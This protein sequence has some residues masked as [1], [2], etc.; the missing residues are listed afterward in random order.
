MFKPYEFNLIDALLGL[1]R[2]E[3]EAREAID[4][5][6]PL[7]F[8]NSVAI[9]AILQL[10]SQLVE[11][12]M[13]GV[14]EGSVA[15]MFAQTAVNALI[16]DGHV[17]S[18]DSGCCACGHG[19]GNAMT[20]KAAIAQ[21]TQDIQ[22]LIDTG[23]ISLTFDGLIDAVTDLTGLS[24]DAVSSAYMDVADTYSKM[25]LPLANE[26]AGTDLPADTSTTGS[27]TVGG[28]ASG[29]RST[30]TDEDWFAI[31]LEAGVEY[32]F[33]M[34][35]SGDNPHED[36]LLNLYD[37]NGALIQTNDD[38]DI[39]GD[40]A[41]E[42]RNSLMFFTATESGTFYLGASGWT[43]T[44]GDYTVF[45][46]RSDERPDFSI[47]EQAFF[48]TD[49]FDNPESWNQ[50]TITYDVSGLADGAKTLA[51]AAMELWAEAS[52]IVF[53]ESTGGTADLTFNEDNGEDDGQ[54]AFASTT[55]SNGVITSARITVS[56][57]WDLNGDGSANYAF[58]S[59]RYQTY[60]HEVGHALGLG[61]AGPYNGI[62]SSGGRDFNV[63]NQDAWNY[64]VMSYFD[65]GEAGTGTPRLVL[66]LQMADIYAI[67][68]LYG[69]N[70]A[71]RSGDTVY[72]FNSTE[73]GIL[74]FET[75][76][77]DQG[78]RPPSLAFYDAGGADTF[79]F[80]GYSANQTISLVAGTFSS[81]GDNT[82]TASTTDALVNNVSI[83]LGTVIENAIGGSG[84][85]TLTGNSAD[86]R[87]DGGLGNDT[88]TGG[89]G[90]DT[91]VLSGANSG[92]DVITDFDVSED[93]I[94]LS[95][96]TGFDSFDAIMAA[97][98]ENGGNV[99]IDLSGGN[100]LTLNGVSM[101]TLTAEAFGFEG[102]TTPPD[103]TVTPPEDSIDDFG[104]DLDRRIDNLL[105]G[106]VF[107]GTTAATASGDQ[108]ELPVFD[109][110]WILIDIP[111]L[112]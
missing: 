16:D 105:D 31:E 24:S 35:R 30:A 41:G 109:E 78:I 32:V 25:S 42:N 46:E 77:F 19:H 58:N 111:E 71:T 61:H 60:I 12:G 93:Q 21:M 62:S 7:S 100:T 36:P 39:D 11:S 52:G 74:N 90:A 82:N 56:E 87:L 53:V 57:N 40:G 14:F 66:G 63:F 44:T 81:I 69:A 23:M 107:T 45:A 79:D 59:Y 80:S 2:S 84:N 89:D 13:L 73:T 55:T 95:G 5:I 48:L 17:Y 104:T 8:E 103:D 33:F 94:D 50:T 38:V 70:T 34:L 3:A 76:F 65:Q 110:S 98:S 92:A 29:T 75:T 10:E 99:L 72:G 54:Q 112:F 85:D 51:I 18:A 68:D 22:T 20:I 96:V 26:G 64:T 91:F 9:E 83:A 88:M 106:S 43:T 86:N 49:Q 101:A 15:Q 27:L 108:A 102:T 97:A 67:Q 37:G 28:R 4:E 47:E 1:S 6:D